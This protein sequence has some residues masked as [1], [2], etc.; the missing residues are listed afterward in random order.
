MLRA[1]LFASLLTA[2]AAFTQDKAPTVRPEVGK[3]LQAA[4]DLLKQRRAKE[5]LAQAR[6]AQGIPD[7][8]PYESYMV[9]RVI[10]QAAAAAGDAASAAAALENAAASSAAPEADRRQLLAMAAGQYYTAK[11]YSK[12]AAVAT[13][14]FQY[15]GTDRSVRTIYINS[16]FQSGNYGGAARELASDVEEQERAGKNPPE[17]Q[18]R[19]LANAYAQSKDTAGYGRTMERLVALYPKRD[20]WLA[21]ID[22]VMRRSGFNERL[23][24]DV[25]RLKIEVGAMQRVDDYVD[26]AQL[27]LIEGFPMEATRVIDKGY[28]GGVLGTGAEAARHKRLKDLAAKNLA[29]DRT[30]IA[31]AEKRDTAG[32]DGKTLFNE[33]FNLVLNDKSA[34]GLAMMEQ[35]LKTAAG[36]RRPDHAKLQLGYAYHLAGQNA[37]ALDLFKVVQG[38]D[39]A[40]ALA[41]LWVI[42]LN[43][44]G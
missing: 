23:Q 21:V 10:G 7:K 39:G 34:K 17:D 14:Y 44:P 16:L 32:K 1:L 6:A 15:A 36:F 12:A 2:T 37:K 30:A 11:E 38:T 22:N 4:I 42:K 40:A 20:Y 8:T 29:E 9:T 43:R 13:R 28:A 31:D 18:L 27:A 5:A 25:A 19:L 41:R 3:P 26:Y 35:C 24:I 33:G